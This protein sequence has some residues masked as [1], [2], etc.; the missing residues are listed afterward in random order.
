MR[1]LCIFALLLLASPALATTLTYLVQQEVDQAD[2][3]V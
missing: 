2:T 1:T 3:F